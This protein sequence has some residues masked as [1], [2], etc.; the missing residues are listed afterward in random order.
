MAGQVL[1]GSVI[2]ITINGKEI[3]CELESSMSITVN[4]SDNDPCKP[5]STEAYKAA[6]WTDP[7]VDSKSWEITF[8]AKAFA[9]SVE[10]NNLDMLELLIN[11]DPIVE[12]QFYTKQ[13]PDYDFDEIAIFSGKGVLSMDDWTAP[14]EGE[15]TYSGTIAGKGKP[16]F[17]RTPI[18]T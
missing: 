12:V 10:F 11:G 1:P 14:A 9:D 7:T 4:T 5:S 6:K 8:N 13:H 2:G 16:T 3:Q 17:V 18:T 15:S